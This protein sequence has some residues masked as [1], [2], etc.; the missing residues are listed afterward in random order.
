MFYN[1]YIFD[2]LLEV[3]F[4]KTWI[5]QVYGGVGFIGQCIVVIVSLT[6]AN[7]TQF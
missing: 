3:G 5:R 1:K 4:Y 2:I 6:I 7:N